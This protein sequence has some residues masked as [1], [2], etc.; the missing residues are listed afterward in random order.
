MNLTVIGATSRTGAHVLADAARRGHAVTVLTRRPER[1]CETAR[2]ARVVVGDGRDPACVGLAVAGADAVIAIVK[3]S[4]RK[5]PHVTAEVAEVIV[6]AMSTL[7]VKRLVM[8]SAYP[9]V[10]VKPRLPMAV[11]RRL[12]REGYADM[13][14]MERVLGASG[15]DWTVARLHGLLD[16]PATG[17]VQTS[18]G[19]FDRPATLARAD[20]ASALLDLV[21]A[22]GSEREAVNIAGVPTGARGRRRPSPAHAG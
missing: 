10:A 3:A 4:S 13:L 14:R 20:A 21:V 11:M 22:A 18:R 1:L 9:V 17:R 19:Q 15:L 12:L 2:P 16:R 6:E 7:R 5:G 8:T